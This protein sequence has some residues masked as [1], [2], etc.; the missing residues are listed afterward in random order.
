MIRLITEEYREGNLAVHTTTVSFLCI[1]LFK[2]KR[3]STNSLV[4]EQLTA[5]K[6]L[7]KI[8][9]FEHETKD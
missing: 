6:E 5:I 4:V 7:T 8:K 9:G 2:C 1:P 3:T